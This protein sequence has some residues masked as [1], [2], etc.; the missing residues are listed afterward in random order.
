MAGSNGYGNNSAG[1]IAAYVGQ[2]TLL[3]YSREHELESDRLGLRLMHDAGYD[4]RAMVD[5]MR[6]LE[7]ASGGAPK[8]PEFSATHPNPGRR[9]EEIERQI[10]ENWP[11]GLPE[12]LKK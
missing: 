5:V 9:V 11:R 12:T 7:Q 3:K 1:Q 4:P 10:K 2:F 6:I 8:G